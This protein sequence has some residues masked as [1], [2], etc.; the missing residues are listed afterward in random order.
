[1]G[2]VRPRGRSEGSEQA[3]REGGYL[4]FWGRRKGVFT[5]KPKSGSVN[6][7]FMRF[8]ITIFPGRVLTFGSRGGVASP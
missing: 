8:S 6:S 1:M 2:M 4:Y 5:K 7:V 3:E